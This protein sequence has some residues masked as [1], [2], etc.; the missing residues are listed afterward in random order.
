M[1]QNKCA[2]MLQYKS[3]ALSRLFFAERFEKKGTAIFLRPILPAVLSAWLTVW[4][5]PMQLC[6]NLYYSAGVD[7][8]RNRGRVRVR[9]RLRLKNENAFWRSEER[10]FSN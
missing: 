4:R 7:N 9:G 1:E 10:K 8:V 3:I 2:A 6:R 5:H